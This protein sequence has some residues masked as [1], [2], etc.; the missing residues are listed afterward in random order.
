MQNELLQDNLK[1]EPAAE[2][3]WLEILKL[4][5]ENDLTFWFT[6]NESSKN[7]YIGKDPENKRIICCFSIEFENT[8]GIL[9]SFAISKELHG[10]GIG[11]HI[12]NNNLE[13]L[14]QQLGIKKLYAA[15]IEAPQFWAKTIFKEID[16]VKT[17]VLSRGKIS[18][19][20]VLNVIPVDLSSPTIL[21]ITV[22]TKQYGFSFYC[23]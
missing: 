23:R 17:I 10:K 6:G 21:T 13:R 14:G 20:S 11:K 2:K 9:K 5:E 15:S 16:N 4:L 8:I 19:S 3:D 22:I 7:F 12:V 18:L 1:I